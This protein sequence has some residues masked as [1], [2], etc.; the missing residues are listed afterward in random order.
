VNPPESTSEPTSNAGRDAAAGMTA[1]TT[2]VR[3]VA[4]PSSF[5]RRLRHWWMRSIFSYLL[6]RLVMGMA[7]ILPL[8]P[9]LALGRFGA[10]IVY[11]FD[12]RGR[13]VA[14]Q[15]LAMIFPALSRAERQRLMRRNYAHLGICS[16][17][18]ARLRTI[19]RARL[20]AQIVPEPGALETTHAALAEGRGV[21]AVSSHIGSWELACV[22]AREMG[23]E[24]VAIAPPFASPYIE[25]MVKGIRERFGSKIIHRR[26]AL[27]GLYR[28]L[29]QG[30]AAA[31]TSDF[32]GGRASPRIPF[33]GRPANTFDGSAWLHLKT[34][35]PLVMVLMLR[36]PDGRYNW[37]VKRIELPELTGTDSE[38][39]Y[40]IMT[41]INEEYE[42][43]IREFPEQWLWRHKRWR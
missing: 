39:V 19:S 30:K 7:E 29:K 26:G 42:A 28:A 5:Y 15:N 36:R 17:E 14:M 18:L 35:A 3:A 22:A 21:I 2:T 23:L 43:V 33:F 6:L 37:R 41:R 4:P 13:R 16:A 25:R 32:Y 8:K 10:W 38:K 40:A 12:R 9:A 20:L 11:L 24:T 34:G 31:I 27:W 1:T